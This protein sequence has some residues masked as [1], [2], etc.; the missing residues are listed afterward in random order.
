QLEDLDFVGEGSF[1]GLEH[2]DYVVAVFFLA[3]KQAALAVL[4][5]AAGLDD[6]A[7]GVFLH[8]FDGGI[9]VIEVLVRDDGDAGFLKFFLAE[10]AIVFEIV[11]VGSAADDG[12]ACG[13]EGLGFGALAQGVVKDDDVGPFAVFIVVAGFGDK[14]VGDVAFFFVFDVV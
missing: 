8:E 11:G 2:A 5:F 10:R 4:S 13:A 7:V 12:L 14:A 6:V 1:V 3:D 9:E